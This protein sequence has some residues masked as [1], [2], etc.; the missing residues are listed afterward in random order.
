MHHSHNSYPCIIPGLLLSEKVAV[1]II[2]KTRLDDD[3]SRLLSRE[4]SCMERLCHRHLVKLFEVHESFSR[5][6]LVMECAGEGDLQSRVDDNGPFSEAEARAVF[7]Q[8]AAGIKHMVSTYNT[9]ILWG[10]SCIHVSS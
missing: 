3:T 5:L 7:L 1:K 8:I 10:H 9:C 2:D 4:I 6:C